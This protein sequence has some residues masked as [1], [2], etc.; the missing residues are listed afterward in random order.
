[1][2]QTMEY[3]SVKIPKYL[4][5]SLDTIFEK[6]G[7]EYIKQ[8]AQILEK[9]EKEMM[10]TILPKL[11]SKESSLVKMYPD[12]EY[13]TCA[14]IP[15]Y[16]S[17]LLLQHR[18]RLPNVIGTQRCIHHQHIYH[19][20]D[21]EPEISVTRVFVKDSSEHDSMYFCDE[22]TQQVYNKD[23]VVIGT[24]HNDKIIKFVF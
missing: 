18:C 17:Q 24:R 21:I 22:K 8:A 2:L 9:D 10:K 13:Y 1:M 15:N 23:G 14:H 5:D 19:I 12:Q 20:E 16:K 11:K 7:R 4:V 3:N 6:V